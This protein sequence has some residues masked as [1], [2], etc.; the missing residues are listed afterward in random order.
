MNAYVYDI[1]KIT[2]LTHHHGS[3]TLMQRHLEYVVATKL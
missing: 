1:I 2:N 3:K